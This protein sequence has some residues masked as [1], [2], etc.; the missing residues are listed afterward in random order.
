MSVRYTTLSRTSIE[1]GPKSSSPTPWFRR[2]ANALSSNNYTGISMTPGAVA[3]TKT[4]W[5]QVTASTSERIGQIRLRMYNNYSLVAAQSTLV[6]I[7]IG[8]AGS[9]TVIIANLALGYTTNIYGGI[10]IDIPINIPSGTRVAIRTQSQRTSYSY[11]INVILI[12]S[13]DPQTT[14]SSVD[15]LGTSTANSGNTAMS[16]ASG[17]YVQIIAATTK[18]Y[19]SLIVVP[20]LAPNAGLSG[21]I[22][23]TYTV[24]VGAAGSEVDIAQSV[25]YFEAGNGSSNI[26]LPPDNRGGILVRAGSRI[27][28]KHNIASGPSNYGAC[29]IGVPYV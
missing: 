10:V 11:N 13:S 15:V 8:A 6:D 7:G 24:A 21:S 9:E 22:T 18:D 5:T 17:T 4:A 2:R 1:R 14:P 27:S 16:G 23:I 25:L 26:M 28:V 12:G 3:N 29:V 19:Q 20:S